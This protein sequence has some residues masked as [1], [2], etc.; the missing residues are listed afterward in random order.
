MTEF[1]LPGEKELFFWINGA[2]SE[3]MDAVMSLYSSGKIWFPA[4]L[5][6]LFAVVY[7]K[8][9][10]E[11]LLVL[12]FFVIVILVCDFVSARI[13]KP[14]V[15]RPRPTSFPGVM[16]SVR[17]LSGKISGRVSYGFI[18][19]HATQAFGF[20]MF[21]SLLF[22]NKLY[23]WVIFLWAVIMAY[24]R[25]YLAA[26]FFSDVLGGAVMGMLV[27]FLLY[28][29]YLLITRFGE[30]RNI[31]IPA[32]YSDKRIRL[33]SLLLV[34]YIVSFSLIQLW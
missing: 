27:G 32:R 8:S 17:T 28:R 1:L 2:H 9:W 34:A 5:S 30:K 25:I 31:V 10:K 13:F 23:S 6:V 4:A 22:R 16:E 33:L 21:T 7:K 14:L 26:H 29:I 24:S 20:A 15:A 12:L 11:W 3:F 18:S 19:G